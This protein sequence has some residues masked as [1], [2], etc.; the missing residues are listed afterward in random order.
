MRHSN[1]F[2]FMYISGVWGGVGGGGGENFKLPKG[3]GRGI[4]KL[5]PNTPFVQFF[6]FS[7]NP[8]NNVKTKNYEDFENMK[9]MKHS[10]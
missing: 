4:L 2:S 6:S 8:S 5:H 1:P 9:L 7:S 3:K 10:H